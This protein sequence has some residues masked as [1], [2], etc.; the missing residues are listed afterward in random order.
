MFQY[1][2]PISSESRHMRTI[3]LFFLLCATVSIYGQGPVILGSGGEQ[4]IDVLTSSDYQASGWQE[5][6]SGDKTMSGEGLD[7]RVMEASRFLSQ[8]TFG[9]NIETAHAVATMDF[10]AWID[11][12]AEIPMHSMLEETEQ[13]WAEVLDWYFLN[14]GDSSEVDFGRPYWNTFSYAWWNLN[15][16]NEDELRQRVAFALSEIF[17]VS[18][19]T[20]LGGNA[21]GLSS[22]YDVLARNALGNYRDLL[23]EVT[24]H[25]CMGFYLSH[26]NNPRAIPEL[27]IHPDENYAREVQQLFSIGLYELNQDGT[28]KTNG[29]GEWIPTYG[30]TQIKEFAK[31][32]TGLGVSEVMPNMYFDEPEFFLNIYFADMT[33]PMKMYEEWHHQGPKHLLNGF[34]IPAGQSGME[35]IEDAIDNLFNH[36]NVGPF[37]GK[38][39]IQKLVTSNPS[40]QY[41]SRVAAAFN[42]NGQ[43]VRGDMKALIKAILLDPEARSCEALQDPAF[44]KLRE[45]FLRYAHFAHG[46]DIE[47][48]YGRYWNAGYDFYLSTGQI[49]LG[50]PSVFNFYLPDFQPNGPI[51]DAGLVGPEFQ[52]HNSRTSVEFINQVNNWAVWQYVWGSWE[53]ADPYTTLDLRELEDLARDPE[54]LVNHLD[55]VF[56]HGQLSNETRTIIKDAIS[57]MISGDYRYHRARM[58]LYLIMIS[59]DYAV[60]K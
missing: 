9:A 39:L 8:A 35:D 14:G 22:Y 58:A 55:R 53:Y 42:D 26:L 16:T 20:D 38:Q 43:G 32:F 46:T 28:R 15:M 7:A 59:P 37:I 5:I 51:I 29:Q 23:R 4:P 33:K 56:T 21:F 18:L 57:P 44:G 25:P 52:I 19:I 41:V 17:V 36:P 49:P 13:V 11:A 27:N 50:A 47:Q 10:G 45:P 48:Y 54:V 12:Q 40:P 31:V 24:L 60:L 2:H 3:T 1:T 34:T 6:A 30:Q